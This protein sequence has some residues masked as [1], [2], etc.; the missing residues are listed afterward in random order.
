[1]TGDVGERAEGGL[2]AGMLIPDVRRLDL[3]RQVPGLIH[4][5]GHSHVD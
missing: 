5:D 2:W 4:G 3:D 1:M